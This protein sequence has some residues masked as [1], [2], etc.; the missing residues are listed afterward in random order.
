VKAKAL[1]IVSMEA[2]AKGAVGHLSIEASTGIS[3]R[4]EWELHRLDKLKTMVC[5]AAE[6]VK[7]NR[8]SKMLERAKKAG[9]EA[10]SRAKKAA[11]EAKA[12]EA[13]TSKLAEEMEKRSDEKEKEDKKRKAGDEKMDTDVDH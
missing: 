9:D 8:I 6:G 13:L 3:A 5:D 11:G 10:N 2:D 12:S 7:R 1:Q 4:A